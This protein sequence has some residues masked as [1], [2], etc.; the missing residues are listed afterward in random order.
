M[1]IQKDKLVQDLRSINKAGLDATNEANHVL[2]ML[3]DEKIKKLLHKYKYVKF[4]NA[5]GSGMV[6][7]VKDRLT[8]ARRAL[9]ISRLTLAEKPFGPHNPV[10]VD[11]EMEALALVSHQNI[12]RFY[13]GIKLASGHYVIITQLVVKPLSIDDWLHQSI[14]LTGSPTTDRELT[15]IF[16]ML[17]EKLLGYAQSLAYMHRQHRLYHMDVKPGNLLVAKDGTPFLTDLGFARWRDKYEDSDLVPIGFTYGFNHPDLLKTKFGVPSTLARAYTVRPARELTPRYDLYAFGRTMLA[18]LKLLEDRF[19][20]R[21]HG[22]Y[23]FLFL[24]LT[25]AMLLDAKNRGTP[26]GTRELFS[27]EVSFNLE[28]PILKTL[29]FRS[30]EAVLDRFERLLGKSS[31]EHRI[32][33][34]D[35]WYPRSVNHGIGFLNLTPR[36][37]ALI[38]H[39][40]FRRLR[41]IKQ[42]GNVDEV[43]LGASHTRY[44]HSEGVV[45][46]ACACLQALY[47]D[48]ENPL[49]KVLVEER[50]ISEVIAAALLHD[51]GQSEFGHDLEELD[52]AFNHSKITQ[53]ILNNASYQDAN[54]RSLKAIL[55]GNGPDEWSLDALHVENILSKDKLLIRFS[56]FRDL[57]DGPLDA[58]KI[59]YLVR[60]SKASGV[61][62]G[63]AL[64]IHR[65]LRCLTVLPS[66]H[67]HTRE[68]QLR[69]GIKEKGLPSS[70]MIVIVRQKMYYSV[71]LHHAT[72][73]LKCMVMHAARSSLSNLR[74]ELGKA[75]LSSRYMTEIIRGLFTSWLTGTLPCV[76]EK[77]IRAD[78]SKRLEKFWKTHWA[79]PS[80]APEQF[81]LSMGFFTPFC[82]PAARLLLQDVKSRRLY[83]RLWERS[84]AS[85]GDENVKTMEAK[86][87]WRCRLKTMKDVE[88]KLWN[89]MKEKIQE[90]LAESEVPDKSEDL[91]LLFKNKQN[92]F[93]LLADMPFRGLG[94]GGD[95][96]PMLSDI[97][98]KRGHYTAD[99][100]GTERIGHIWREGAGKMM[101]EA[102]FCRIFCEPDFHEYLFSV[103]DQMA[104]ESAISQALGLDT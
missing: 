36:V 48:P 98:R 77:H 18:L 51:L 11:L 80:L 13:D 33:E 83:K 65:L 71:Y 61:S 28:G 57:L 24:H 44:A 70:E 53:L 68:L 72:R 55:E 91:K 103:I 26:A 64:D 14:T 92:R 54:G 10:S 67:A 49:F 22:N 87:Q 16:M 32:S 41:Y 40:G 62:H 27:N 15:H 58:D 86:L 96:P 34:L 78:A 97:S 102:C 69:L 100:G 74:I 46:A 99:D 66:K 8:K 79:K 82:K 52:D 30:F 43:Y 90:N 3:Q 23:G 20:E 73:A 29:A 75:R 84:F 38:E 50:D 9:K 85:L 45:G 95:T 88:Q 35:P 63:Q 101:K 19:Q 37:Q 5:G 12:T 81:D 6:F 94:P 60:D 56:A 93:L 7:E 2:Q 89:I 39:P 21:I 104:V 4:I 76:E 17:T 1:Q 42:L 47:N 31:I 59:D 25:A